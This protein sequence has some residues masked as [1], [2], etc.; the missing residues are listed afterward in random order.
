LK[1]LVSLIHVASFSAAVFIRSPKFTSKNLQ[2][3]AAHSLEVLQR[4]LIES[5]HIF[6]NLC[7]YRDLE[8]VTSVP[9]SSLQYPTAEQPG[10]QTWH[11]AGGWWEHGSRNGPT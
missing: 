6:D 10:Q 3:T 8:L 4:K 7:N 5:L 9:C 11:L 1:S 2:T